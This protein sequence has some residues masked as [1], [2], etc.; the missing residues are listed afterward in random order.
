MVTTIFITSYTISIHFFQNL[1]LNDDTIPQIKVFAWFL[2]KFFRFNY[3]LIWVQQDQ[4]AYINFPKTFDE[5]DLLTFFIRDNFE[6][7][8]NISPLELY[9]PYFD[10]ITFDDN[11]IVEDSETSYS[12]PLL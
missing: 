1:T 4:S 10:I 9:K 2:S 6:Q 11:F 5:I 12:R 3:Q 7:S 8:Q